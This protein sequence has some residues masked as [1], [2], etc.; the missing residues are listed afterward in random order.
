[1]WYGPIQRE[2]QQHQHSFK[3]TYFC[4]YLMVEHHIAESHCAICTISDSLAMSKRATNAEHQA[5]ST[6]IT[7][8]QH[9]HQQRCAAEHRGRM[10]RLQYSV[11][12]S[13]A[14][15]Q[16]QHKVLLAVEAQMPPAYSLSFK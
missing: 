15:H 3:W 13:G 12:C 1:M 14:I 16:L 8:L 11:W 7:R 4:K 9:R 10:G 5:W 2:C 6:S